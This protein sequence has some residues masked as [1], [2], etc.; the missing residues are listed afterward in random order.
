MR[1]IKGPPRPIW[2]H[3]ESEVN[4]NSVPFPSKG[5]TS[6]A[7]SR[8]GGR[9]AQPGSGKDSWAALVRRSYR[10]GVALS[11]EPG[12]YWGL[13]GHGSF[14]ADSGGLTNQGGFGG[15]IPYLRLSPDPV[16]NSVR[17]RDVLVWLFAA[18]GAHPPWRGQAV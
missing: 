17:P 12:T 4:G 11:S 7:L 15:P 14:W 3:M 16:R 6:R 18:L 10:M 8:L 13:E 5:V 1:P 9:G 2:A